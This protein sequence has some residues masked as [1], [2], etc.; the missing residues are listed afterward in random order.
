[1]SD[2]VKKMKMHREFWWGKPEEKAS[3]ATPRCR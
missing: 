1:M 3:L 2:M